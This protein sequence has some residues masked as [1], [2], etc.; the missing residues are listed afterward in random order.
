MN[1]QPATICTLS[2]VRSSFYQPITRELILEQ[3]GCMGYWPMHSWK[4][5]WNFWLFQINYNCPFVCVCVGGNW[6][7]N[8]PTLE[9]QNLLQLKCLIKNG[10]EQ[11]IKLTLCILRIPEAGGKYCFHPQLVKST[12]A[13]PGNTEGW[14]YIYWKKY[15]YRW[16]CAVQTLLLKGQ[17][18]LTSTWHNIED[19]WILIE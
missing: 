11:C 8:P 19:Q 18:C 12:D 9:Y 14:L 13:K 7:Q 5:M 16:I 17:L 6:F 15:V 1:K 2:E 10:I 3:C 4:S